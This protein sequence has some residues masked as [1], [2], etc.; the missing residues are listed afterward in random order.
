[1]TRFSHFPC[2]LYLTFLSCLNFITRQSGAKINISDGSCPERIVTVS[3][4]T[5]A[6]Y[7][8]FT[9]ITKKFEEVSLVLRANDFSFIPNC[10]SCSWLSYLL[11]PS[12]NFIQVIVVNI[13]YIRKYSS[14]IPKWILQCN[15]FRSSLLFNVMSQNNFKGKAEEN[16]LSWLIQCNLIATITW[17]TKPCYVE[18]RDG[19]DK[20]QA[21][22]SFK[23]RFVS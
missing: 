18:A 10:F 16:L 1:M 13:C 9:L 21:S 20:S 17:Y 15:C 7:K 14:E 12:V 6:I 22:K 3:G 19:D 8:A 2:Q 5:S 4:S 11:V 23:L